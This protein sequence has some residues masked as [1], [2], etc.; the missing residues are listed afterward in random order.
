MPSAVSTR[1]NTH[2]ALPRTPVN[3]K[4]STFVI[5]SGVSGSCA[6]IDSLNLPDAIRLPV[7]PQAACLIK[8]RRESPR[9]C[10]LIDIISFIRFENDEDR[11]LRGGRRFLRLSRV[12]LLP[13]FEHFLEFRREA[14]IDVARAILAAVH[15]LGFE[16]FG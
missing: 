12:R 14:R 4:G 11:A 5:L 13:L 2:G 9:A 16:V 6:K 3:R 10:L 1:T 8:E 15:H 7:R